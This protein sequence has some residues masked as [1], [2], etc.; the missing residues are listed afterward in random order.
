MPLVYQ[1][2]HSLRGREFESHRC[3]LFF[4]FSFF[5]P[6]RLHWCYKQYK[7]SHHFAEYN[8]MES[9]SAL[10]SLWALR[11]DVQC[12]SSIREYLQPVHTPFVAR[13]DIW[14][15]GVKLPSLEPGPFFLHDWL[16][17]LFTTNLSSISSPSRYCWKKRTL[18][19]GVASSQSLV[20][21]AVIDLFLW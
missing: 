12:G 14:E 8:L 10:F 15:V 13:R 3:R 1:P 21:S 4:I 17:K 9:F 2:S 20:L 18:G 16:S 5:L 19:H 11:R 7:P 6:S